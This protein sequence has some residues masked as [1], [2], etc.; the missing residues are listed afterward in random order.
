MKPKDPSQMQYLTI[1]FIRP[2]VKELPHL[3]SEIQRATRRYTTPRSSTSHISHKHL[4]FISHSYISALRYFHIYMCRRSFCFY[5][6]ELVTPTILYAVIAS[7]AYNNQTFF[8]VKG[9]DTTSLHEYLH[10]LEFVHLD[11]V[12]EETAGF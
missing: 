5:F 4:S 7:N 2:V 6:T 1:S 9:T 10:P 11:V 8:T 3:K 12:D